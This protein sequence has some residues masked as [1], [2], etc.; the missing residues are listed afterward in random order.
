MKMK[1]R[2]FTCLILIACGDLR[3]LPFVITGG[4]DQFNRK[5]NSTIV[6]LNEL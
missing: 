1:V 2:N 4:P 6:E 3:D 5:E